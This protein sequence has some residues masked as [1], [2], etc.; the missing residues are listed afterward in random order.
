[1]MGG[2]PMGG[3]VMGGGMMGGVMGMGGGDRRQN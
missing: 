2:A 3:G 1:M